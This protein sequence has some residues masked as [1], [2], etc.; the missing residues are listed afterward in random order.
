MDNPVATVFLDKITTFFTWIIARM[1][2]L[3][4]F[5]T[6]QEILVY[7]IGIL[8]ISLVIGVLVRLIRN[9]A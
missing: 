3:L 2:E 8:F 4:T 1:G 5:I 9:R 7:L 6:G